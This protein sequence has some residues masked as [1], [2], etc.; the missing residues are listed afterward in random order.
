MPFGSS[1]FD[2]LP[3]PEGFALGPTAGFAEV[4]DANRKR[5][6][7]V[8]S[9]FGMQVNIR[10]AY[11]QQLDKLNAI[12]GQENKPNW[13]FALDA[14]GSGINREMGMPAHDI[15]MPGIVAK[16][17]QYLTDIDKIDLALNAA[18]AKDP[19][20][21][22][23]KE[24]YNDEVA[25]RQ[26]LIADSASVTGR[27]EQGAKIGSITVP[28]A[29]PE[30]LGGMVGSLDPQRDPLFFGTMFLP[31]GA[32]RGLVQKMF[33]EALAGGGV[34]AAQELLFTNPRAAALG[35]PVPDLFTS[36]LTAAVTSAAIRGGL[37]GVPPALRGLRDALPAPVR[38]A[39]GG[40]PKL[41]D[42]VPHLSD[43]ELLTLVRRLP[44][45]P[46]ARAAEVALQNE[47]LTKETTPLG[48]DRAGL[49]ATDRAV[50]EAA[51]AF[52]EARP[53]NP[54]S[55][56]FREGPTVEQQ[57][58]DVVRQQNPDLYTQVD[59][60]K[61]QLTEAQQ[62]LDLLNSA[63]EKIDRGHD[64]FAN[65]QESRIQ[66]I[67]ADFQ[68]KLEEINA[69]EAEAKATGQPEG[70]PTFEELRQHMQ[71][72]TQ[73]QLESEFSAR[74]ETKRILKKETAIAA[75][76]FREATSQLRKLQERTTPLE[77]KAAQKLRPNEASP[78]RAAQPD[79]V[80]E[81]KLAETLDVA[82]QADEVAATAQKALKELETKAEPTA[83]TKA[84][85]AQIRA[86]IKEGKTVGQIVAQLSQPSPAVKG[87][88]AEADKVID[89][90]TVLKAYRQVAK[91][92]DVGGKEVP[93]D[94]AIAGPDGLRPA[95]KVV[96][97]MADE[98]A[99]LTATTN[100][101]NTGGKATP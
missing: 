8:D 60:I 3:S 57:V 91:T 92:I 14:I 31:M 6:Q 101:A 55:V 61:Q 11:F 10:D 43:E 47:I 70:K 67:K 94:L 77:A 65:Q 75:K 76:K 17:S 89:P 98:D 22:T 82:K 36:V 53:M 100:C 9:A 50:N 28:A 37:E 54:D 42:Y 25:K 86:L 32:A 15:T 38:D 74:A 20:V 66:A 79:P 19:S 69:A 95:S 85:T 56:L 4:F 63:R 18:K 45:N 1:N 90:L 84:L 52:E 59:T 78:A 51:A 16:Q 68:Q 93:R 23:F 34:T 21:K 49:A 62:K 26:A 58:Q 73:T 12:T 30:F 80:Q 39:L 24:L 46:D 35:E 7:M 2:H 41:G 81:Q 71:R 83:E 44:D 64:F 72:V 87:L 5:Q 27:S 40:A 99:M 97:E 13:N 33:F 96:E 88:A 29:I 48:T